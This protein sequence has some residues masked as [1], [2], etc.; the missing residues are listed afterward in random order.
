MILLNH[1]ANAKN[2]DRN[3]LRNLVDF[4]YNK[5]IE[6]STAAVS[7]NPKRFWGLLRSKIKI[8][9][10]P[11]SVSDQGNTCSSSKDK[12]SMFNNFFYSNFTHTGRNVTFPFISEFINRHLSN[13]STSISE[14]RLILDK[15]DPNKATGPG[16]H[17]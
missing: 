8:K 17:Q 10:I 16:I 14:T 11:T 1:G 15:I 9:N 5:Y 3:K 13:I 12:A 2:L 6:D 4:K 7:V